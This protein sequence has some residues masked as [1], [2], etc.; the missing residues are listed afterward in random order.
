MI[1]RSGLEG[2]VLKLISLRMK[3]KI[4]VREAQLNTKNLKLLESQVSV[5]RVSNKP[6]AKRS[7]V[8]KAKRCSL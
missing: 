4:T 7:K 8:S 5:K 6:A 3:A 2:K 1:V